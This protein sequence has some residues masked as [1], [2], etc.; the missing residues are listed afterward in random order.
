VGGRLATAREARDAPRLRAAALAR[1][2]VAGL[3]RVRAGARAGACLRR[4]RRRARGR[5]DRPRPHARLL[6]RSGDDEGELRAAPERR[7]ALR[8]RPPTR[9]RHRDRRVLRHGRRAEQLGARAGGAPRRPQAP[10]PRHPPGARREAVLRRQRVRARP[11]GDRDEPLDGDR[12][13]RRAQVDGTRRRQDR[14]DA[15]ALRAR[16][17]LPDLRLPAVPQAAR[18]LVVAR[19]VAVRLPRG[20]RRRGDER[21]VAHLPPTRVPPGLQLVRRLGPRDQHR[22]R[23]RLHDRLPPPARGAARARR[24]ARPARARLAADGL[25]V[26]PARLPDRDERRGRARD[27]DLPARHDRA[28]APLLHPRPRLRAPLPAR[29]RGARRAGRL[30][31]AARPELA[32]PAASLPLRPFRLDGRLLRSQ[33]RHPGCPGGRL[34]DPGAGGAR[35]RVRARARGGR[36]GEQDARARVRA[37]RGSG[38]AG[39]R[40]RAGARALAA[41]NQDWREAS[42]FMPESQPTLAFHAAGTGPFDGYDIRL[43]RQYVRTDT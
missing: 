1:R 9:A 4:L 31:G 17:S 39:R 2:R 10:A 26:Q 3:A 21:S 8:R 27:H 37:V 22:D 14:E 24:G 41:V 42:R 5:G 15:A 20:G 34:L 43:K 28:E 23:E 35:E 16:L 19:L 40:A 32:R 11:V 13:H 18:R 36:K 7:G 29:G 12:G 30:A 25:P 33:R 38:A 6:A